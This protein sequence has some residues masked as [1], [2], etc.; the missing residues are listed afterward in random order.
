LQQRVRTTP[1]Q[2]PAALAGN[3]SLNSEIFPVKK[4]HQYGF[5]FFFEVILTNNKNEKVKIVKTKELLPDCFCPDD[6]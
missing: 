2:L 6:M 3:F 1:G 4:N 5:K